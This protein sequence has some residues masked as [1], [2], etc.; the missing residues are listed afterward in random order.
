MKSV[1]LYS[2]VPSRGCFACWPVHYNIIKA[3]TNSNHILKAALLVGLYII[4]T[5]TYS[6]HIL[7]VG[8][9]VTKRTRWTGQD[10]K[11][12]D[13]T[14]NSDLQGRPVCRRMDRIELR[15]HIFKAGLSVAEWI[16]LN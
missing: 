14:D 16:E 10:E 9:S 6:N 1:K 8:L 15:N 11:D 3:R 12:W 4:K 2:L 5:R 7:K 13:G